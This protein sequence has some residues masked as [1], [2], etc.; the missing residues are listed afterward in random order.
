MLLGMTGAV[1]MGGAGA[2]IWPTESGQY[3]LGACYGT[4]EGVRCDL[5]YT[6][7]KKQT[8]DLSASYHN[9]SAFTADGTKVNPKVSLAGGD[10]SSYPSTKV[11]SGTPVKVS[12]LF[13][14]PSN[15]TSLAALA[16]GDENVQRVPVRPFGTP[17]A[18]A[19]AAAPTPLNIAG[20]WNATLT[21]CR[22]NGPGVV[23]CTATLRK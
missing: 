17:A 11:Y 6:L 18:P 12:L 5:T 7:T 15:I 8:L 20:N 10:W 2:Q 13:N 14:I 9:F 1:L 21:N 16:I 19:Q 23:V 22:Q 4:K 3:K